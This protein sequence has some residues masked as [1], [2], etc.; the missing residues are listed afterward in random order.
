MNEA[1]AG[2]EGVWPETGK[3]VQ[4]PKIA[5]GLGCATV[6]TALSTEESPPTEA[7]SW[8]VPAVPIERVS[9]V[10]VPAN[11]VTMVV[12]WRVTPAGPVPLLMVM[13]TALAGEGTGLPRSSCNVTFGGPGMSPPVVAFPGWV[14]KTSLAGISS[15]VTLNR[16]LSSGSNPE[17]RAMS[18]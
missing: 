11:V 13:L 4:L 9:K 2:P 12:P 7:V 16:V 5:A 10:A 6:K 8:Y 14:V 15:V 1:S 3:W 18:V 17:E